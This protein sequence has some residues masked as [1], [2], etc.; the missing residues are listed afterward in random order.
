M[1][2]YKLLGSDPHNIFLYFGFYKSPHEFSPSLKTRPR[3]KEYAG[4]RACAI[5]YRI[6]LALLQTINLVM[7]N[8][9][10]F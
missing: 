1:R 4:A 10:F 8:T 2:F 7:G 5:F 3:Y 9:D 6:R